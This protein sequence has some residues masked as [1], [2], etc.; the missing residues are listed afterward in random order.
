VSFAR[1]R[2]RSDEQ[3]DCDVLQAKHDVR[4]K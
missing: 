4:S 3:G 2:A 1:Q